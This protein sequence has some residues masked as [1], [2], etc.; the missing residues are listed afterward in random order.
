MLVNARMVIGLPV[1]KLY[2]PPKKKLAFF[3]GQK[4]KKSRDAHP[5]LMKKI[6]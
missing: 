4:N 6:L 1:L 5:L 3:R 2:P